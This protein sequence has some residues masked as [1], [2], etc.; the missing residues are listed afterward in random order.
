MR[1][2]GRGREGSLSVRE[3]RTLE[4]EMMGLG[5]KRIWNSG[6]EES[7]TLEYKNPKP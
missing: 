6:A 2:V 4:R 3:S 1:E 5:G 7:G